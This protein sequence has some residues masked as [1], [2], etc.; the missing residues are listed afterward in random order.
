MLRLFWISLCLLFSLESFAC[1]RLEGSFSVDGETMKIDQKTVMGQE[2]S[3]PFNNFILSF[4]FHPNPKSAKA[5][6][7][8]YKVEERSA[9]KLE[10][11]SLGEDDI[12]IGQKR[13]IYAKG[14]EKKPH[15]IIDLK[16]N[17]I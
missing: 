15:S 12:R 17:E 2:Y 5:F 10:M 11:V 9:S 7:F 13:Q 1:L 6:N 3:M 8:R 14:L 4:T 16:I